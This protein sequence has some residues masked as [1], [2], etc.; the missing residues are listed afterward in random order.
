M[1]DL[2]TTRR[3]WL[4]R[5]LAAVYDVPFAFDG[6][7]MAYEFSAASGR[8]GLL[9]Q[10]AFLSRFAHPNRSSPTRR[11]VALLDIFLC[12]PTPPPPAGIDFALADGSDPSLKTVRQRLLAHAANPA[13]A[14]CHTG[15]DPLGLAL[16]DFDG[17]GQAR[18]SDHGTAIDVSAVWRGKRFTGARDLG[19][20]LHDDPA[21]PACFARK[22][23]AYGTG[24]DAQKLA[25]PLT[26]GLARTF[27]AAAYRVPALLRALTADPQF[28]RVPPP[29]ARTARR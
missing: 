6:D 25:P 10:I 7:W 27:A 16:E 23:Y 5:D 1:R 9:T 2:L 21:L 11:G 20:M 8:S 14:A 15:S 4:T 17:L 19:R 26:Q 18:A 22:L 28:F 24:A 29:A 13:C 12:Q 3:T